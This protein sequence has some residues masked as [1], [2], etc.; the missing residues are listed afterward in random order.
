MPSNGELTQPVNIF[1]CYA[2]E[3]ELLRNELEKHLRIL[4]RQGHIMLWHDREISAG[5]EWEREITIH[6]NT[7]QIILLLISPDFMDSDYCYSVEMV[8][9][10]KRHD[11]GEACVL[12][13]ILRP[14]HWEDAPFSKIQVLPTDGKPVTRWADRDEAF[15]DIAREI[16]KKVKEQLELI[17]AG[18]VRETAGQWVIKGTTLYNSNNYEEALKAFEQAHILEP[19]DAD[20]I[21]NKGNTL[22]KLKRH[23]EALK[24][25]ERASTMKPDNAFFYYYRGLAL[26]DLTL[27]QEAL[28]AFEQAMQLRPD[29][30]EAQ[31]SKNMI[32]EYIRRSSTPVP[33]RNNRV[34]LIDFVRSDLVRSDLVRSDRVTLGSLVHLR[35]TE[36]REYHYTIV[37]AFDADPRSGRI[38]NESPVGRALLGHK[39]GDEIIVSTPGGVKEYTILRIE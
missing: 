4:K 31:E 25:F 11:A 29:Y 20:I 8:E 27:Y 26:S 19:Q 34:N 15:L 17:S 7:A 22:L 12:P 18:I 24:A 39:E 36:D 37:K 38:S 5:T 1:F 10:I 33:P 6:L 30:K 9:A 35:T 13:I 21:C 14:V 28:V 3:D 2:R 16:R 23:G 32:I